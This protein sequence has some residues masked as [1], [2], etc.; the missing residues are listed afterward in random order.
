MFHLEQVLSMKLLR[1]LAESTAK[2]LARR[3]CFYDQLHY[4]NRRFVAEHFE[5]LAGLVVE[6][7]RQVRPGITLRDLTYVNDFVSP[8]NLSNAHIYVN[9]GV[10]ENKYGWHNDAIDRWLRPCYN[11]WIPLY[12][13]STLAQLDDESLFDVLTPASCPKL[14]DAQ[15]SVRCD[16]FWSTQMLPPVDRQ[17]VS[18]LVG[19]PL[20]SLDDYVYFNSSAGT[21]KVLLSELTPVSVVRPQLGDCYV[22]DSSNQHASGPSGF[23]RVGISVKFLVNN[24]ELGFRIFP[25]SMV[26]VGWAGMFICWYD[27]FRSFRAYQDVI[28]LYIEREQPLLEQNK[29][30][31]ECVRDFLLRVGAELESVATR[32]GF[33]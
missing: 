5:Q 6:A 25:H 32:S 15:G 27:Q 1:E 21:Q 28:D 17:V 11:L 29:D 22:F 14:Y 7:V 24:P 10:K 23:E 9:S 2:G 30:K 33:G 26:P 13:A 3:D 8:V 12:P 20:G 18:R 4:V 19:L 16:Y 31:L